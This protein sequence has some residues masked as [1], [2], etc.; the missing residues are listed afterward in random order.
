MSEEA[1]LLSQRYELVALKAASSEDEEAVRRLEALSRV[2]STYIPNVACEEMVRD[3]RY[4]CIGIVEKETEE[5]VG[6][7][8]YRVWPEDK[9]G[10]AFVELALFCVDVAH[11]DKGLG[12]RLMAGLE[13]TS[14]EEHDASTI[15]AY[16]DNRAFAFFRRLG[17][18]RTV[19]TPFSHWKPKI[20]D[21]SLGAVAANTSAAAA[22][23]SSRALATGVRKCTSGRANCYCRSGRTRAIVRYDPVTGKVLEE[24]CSTSDA[25]RKL[26]LTSP[27]ITHVLSGA[28]EDANGHKFRYAVEVSWIRGAGARA[29]VEIDPAT[30]DVV[31]EFDSAAQAARD[32]GISNS[33]IGLVCSGQRDEVDGRVFRFK[34]PR[35]YP[36]A[37]CGSDH[38]GATLLLCDGLDGRCV[39]TA[40]TTCIGLDAVPDTDWFCE[41][42]RAKGEHTKDK[43]LAADASRA[44]I[45]AKRHLAALAA[46]ASPARS[47]RALATRP[48]HPSKPATR[49]RT[50]MNDDDCA[51]CGD[52]GELLCCDTCERAYHLECA[53]LDLV[54][55]GTWSCDV[56]VT[57][58][59]RTGTKRRK[60]LSSSSSS[61]SKSNKT[62]AAAAAVA[63]P[64]RH[65]YDFDAQP[66]AI[67]SVLPPARDVNAGVPILFPI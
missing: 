17:F 8:C 45:V 10:P 26:H 33:T 50:D 11:Q 9:T 66:P 54:P 32:L 61:S 56:C 38:D 58:V 2:L 5:V 62:K 12:A 36:C 23:D 30:G 49:K 47:T 65:A 14:V 34:E 52:G 29:V 16:A 25:A 40:H 1:S 44:A 59:L 4:E 22:A 39:S 28:K 53:A 19:T 6:G 57:E 67:V 43:R 51:A 15:L 48:Q 21:Y 31:R 20:I 42:C 64:P 60:L 37:V 27:Q 41:R 3:A 63:V 24:Y 55:E 35:I 13:R 46:E 18:S 7:T